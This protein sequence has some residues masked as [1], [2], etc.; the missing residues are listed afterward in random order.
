M[1]AACRLAAVLSGILAI[2]VLAAEPETSPSL[3]VV[4][5]S[6]TNAIRIREPFALLLRVENPA[7][8]N[9]TIRV[10]NCSW[11]EHWQSSNPKIQSMGWDCYKNFAVNVEIPPGSAYTNV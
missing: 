1:I 6:S 8:T 7:A 4:V 11:Y 9:Q 5:I 3:R 2:A 10:M